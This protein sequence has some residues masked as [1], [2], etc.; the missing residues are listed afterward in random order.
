MTAHESTDGRESQTDTNDASTTGA[1]ATDGGQSHADER[2]PGGATTNRPNTASGLEPN[3]AGAATYALGWLTGL[4]FFF[5]EKEDEFVRFHAAQS[6]VAFGALTVAYIVI[7]MVFSVILGSLLLSGGFAIVPLVGLLNMLLGLIGLVLWIGSMYMAYQ[8]R[9][10]EL[11][12]A[13]N[14]ANNM[15]ADSGPSTVERKPAQ[16]R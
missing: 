9:W 11:P 15:I 2:S 8:G 10:F 4:F 14:I 12:I 5:T 7:G 16:Q 6:I 1:T 3:V 13:G